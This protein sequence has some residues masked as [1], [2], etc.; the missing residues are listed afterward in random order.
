MPMKQYL[1]QEETNR[2]LLAI[3]KELVQINMKATGRHPPTTDGIKRYYQPKM[4][5]RSNK[6]EEGEKVN[7]K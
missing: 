2:L 1:L 6:G 5:R 4:A 7:D 3:L